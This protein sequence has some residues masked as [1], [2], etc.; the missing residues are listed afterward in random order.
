MPLVAR[1][2][3]NRIDLGKWAAVAEIVSSA[4]ILATLVYLAIQTKQL[5]TQTEQNTAAIVSSS[6]QESLSAEL[7][8]LRMI[9]DDPITSFDQPLEPGLIGLKQRAVDFSMFR[10]R[11]H[12]WLQYQDGLLDKE[13][14]L[15]YLT[16]LVFN[17]KDS[18]RVR[19]HWN[20]SSFSYSPA[21]VADVTRMLD[22]EQLQ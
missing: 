5:A 20:N 15:S 1:R 17:I 11:E 4:A 7:Q 2:T 9:Y 12:Q 6:R 14:L 19:Q 22:D 21:F 16:V 8:V 13:T 3:M 10:V 18:D